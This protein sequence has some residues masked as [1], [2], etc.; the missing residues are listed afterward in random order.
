MTDLPLA[1]L[2]AVATLLA[3]VAL[4]LWSAR[5]N[6]RLG[7]P[8]YALWLL[9]ARIVYPMGLVVFALA[10]DPRDSWVFWL[11]VG[12]YVGQ[13]YVFGVKTAERLQD[14]G[15]AC[16]LGLL[17]ALPFL[18]LLPAALFLALR[19]AG[20]AQPLP[21]AAALPHAPAVARAA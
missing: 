21:A 18:G 9:W 11:N 17:T 12:A 20:A 4:G 19:P 15:R 3:A 2:A 8:G 16:R 7:R 5:P 14:A 10:L 6:A 13:L 1:A